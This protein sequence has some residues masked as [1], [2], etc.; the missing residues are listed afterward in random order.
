MII[1]FY[2]FPNIMLQ[3]WGS[4]RAVQSQWYLPSSHCHLTSPPF[5]HNPL[6]LA[7]VC[8][9]MHRHS[10]AKPSQCYLNLTLQLSTH[11][12]LWFYCQRS[13]VTLPTL[14]QDYKCAAMKIT[15]W[16][17]CECFKIFKTLATLEG[18][19]GEIMNDDGCTDTTCEFVNFCSSWLV[20]IVPSSSAFMQC[21]KGITGDN[22]N[23]NWYHLQICTKLVQT[24]DLKKTL[25]LS[26]D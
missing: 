4:D 25:S 23:I 6:T 21:E 18:R 5:H 22:A 11:F 14:R 16:Y 13:A 17:G 12:T 7:I 19:T 1:P 15:L 8:L 26:I 3:W 24:H 20:I 10:I 2:L 9:S